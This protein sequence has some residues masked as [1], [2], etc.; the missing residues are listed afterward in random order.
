[1][2]AASFFAPFFCLIPGQV[3]VVGPGPGE[4]PEIQT[5]VDASADGDF[6]LVKSG[7]YASFVVPNRSLTIAAD[8]GATVNVVGAI[9]ARNLSASRAI[10]FSGLNA[11]GFLSANDADA[12]GMRLVNCIGPVTVQDCS[13]RGFESLA[14]A[15]EPGLG[16][17]VESCDAVVFERCTLTGTASHSG[18]THALPTDP[19]ADGLHATNSSIAMYSSSARGG[20]GA[21]ACLGYV[22][23]G[24]PGGDGA[25]LSNCTLVAQDTTFLGGNRGNG[26]TFSGL[27]YG[28]N[29]GQGLLLQGTGS[30]ITLYAS[31]AQGGSGGVGTCAPFC[32]TCTAGF[33]GSS[34][35]DLSGSS[36]TISVDPARDLQL[37]AVARESTSVNVACQGVIGDTVS[38]RISRT[39][40]FQISAP[41]HGVVTTVA[42]TIPER[43]MLL[44]TMSSTTLASTLALGPVPMASANA[45]RIQSL[46]VASDG[47]RWLGDPRV[48]VVLDSIY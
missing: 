11:R 27:N 31:T 45:L 38:L 6:V 24:Q 16:A 19:N 21:L 30:T 9:R 37:A 18:E 7:T 17:L 12:D 8:I 33:G 4:I 46:H 47:T 39:P 42:S 14:C 3:L 2:S 15:P 13:L 5:A 25:D 44:G 10:V 40:T 48:L 32:C 1:M 43:M 41:L 22:G 26:D 34:V 28:G 29:G 35:A 23:D 20:G 36:V